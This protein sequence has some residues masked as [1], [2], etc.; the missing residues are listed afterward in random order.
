MQSHHI[1]HSPTFALLRVDL[2]GNSTVLAETGSMVARTSNVNMEV[3][4]NASKK[5]GVLGFLLA[6]VVAMV[7]KLI[8]G[9]SFFVNHFTAQ[10][11]GDVTE[12]ASVWLAP[13]MSGPIV[14]RQLQG[15]TLVL[16]RGAYLAS[17]GEVDLKMK[18]GGWKGLIAKEGLF[19][20]EVT[21]VGDLWFTSYG[22]VEV[23]EVNGSFVLDNG[24]LVGYEGD[25]KMGIKNAGGGVFGF[26]ASG[27]GLVCEFTGRGRV[28]VQ[29][30][31]ESALID[32]L[33]QRMGG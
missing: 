18:W 12:P 24:H 21:G 13:T 16:S 9:E 17:N 19:M 29:T 15:E 26:V 1:T 28:Y 4:M 22:G 11:N 20:L 7:R 2:V 31:N 25:L 33:L 30:R 14:H 8:G 32:W 23:M 27:E 3:K 6:L 10:R 5:D